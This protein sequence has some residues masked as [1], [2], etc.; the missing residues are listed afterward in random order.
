MLAYAPSGFALPV[1][2]QQL[3]RAM[4]DYSASRRAPITYALLILVARLIKCQSSVFSLWFN[5]RSYE[6]SRGE[7]ITMI[8]EKTMT[9]KIVAASSSSEEGDSKE[10]GPAKKQPASTGKVLNLRNDAYDVAQRFWDFQIFISCPLNLVLSVV[11][12]WKLIGWPCLFGVLT[13]FVAQAINAFI[14]RVQLRW[15]RTRR[16]A[17]DTKLQKINE[18]V[19]AIRHLRWYGWQEFWLDQIMDARK[20]ELTLRIKSS[21]WG[22]LISFTNTLASGRKSLLSLQNLA[23]T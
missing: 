21:L 22:I 16:T 5:R 1:L 10:G 9:R 20:K 4:E 19:E 12:I 15:E 2:L 7:M 11:L 3:L 14:T 18:F 6:R 13:V 17:T 23:L 8:F